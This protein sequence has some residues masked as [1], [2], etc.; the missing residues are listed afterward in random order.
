MES[1]RGVGKF[2]I[3]I[4]ILVSIGYT[5]L[6]LATL[7]GLCDV[8]GH[9][10]AHGANIE[11]KVSLGGEGYHVEYEHVQVR[12]VGDNGGHQDSLLRMEVM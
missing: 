5:S 10:I 3:E 9:L 7:D 2:L 11:A 1:F 8:I 6:H 12:D 4:I